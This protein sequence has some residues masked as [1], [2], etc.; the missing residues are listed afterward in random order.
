M[1]RKKNGTMFGAV[2]IL[3]LLISTI[4]SIGME[5]AK[6][7]P[8]TLGI[9]EFDP[10]SHDFGNMTAGECNRTVFEIWTSGGCCELIF[11]LA[12]NCS[13]VT[14]FPISGVTNGEHIPITVTVNTTS[15]DIGDHVCDIQITTNGGGSGVFNV[16]LDIVSATHPLLVYSPRTYN[17]GVI[18]ENVIKST[19]FEI[20]NGGN[21]SLNYTLSPTKNWI[22]VV[23]LVG[24]SIGEHDIISVTINTQGLQNNTTYQ[25]DIHIDSN[26]GCDVFSVTVTVGTIP[27]FE[28]TTIKGGLF[29]TKAI[30]RN[31]GTANAVSVYW[32]I[33]ISG[34][35]LILLG[36]ETSG[37]ISSLQSGQEETITS[38]T[39]IGLGSVIIST[40]VYST[41][42]MPVTE[43]TT[44]K[45]LLFYIKI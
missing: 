32:K 17:F 37:T 16:T 45:L 1:Y 11:N 25:C 22:A 30:I 36:K 5:P 26:G 28:I 40:M 44:A 15:L 34:N 33:S 31:N 41:E 9:L 20:W 21:G 39:I 3:L 43:K 24:S 38:D 23:P 8:Q 4:G 7:D 6:N 19:A 18:P 27:S 10:K 35:G 42:V 12:W 29:H 14:V 2:V 13:W